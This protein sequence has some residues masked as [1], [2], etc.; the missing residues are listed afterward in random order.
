MLDKKTE[1]DGTGG[2]SLPDSSIAAIARQFSGG[3]LI[4]D[5]EGRILWANQG[6]LNLTG[7]SL[8]ELMGQKPGPL[9]QGEGT[10]PQAVQ[11]ISEHIKRKE[12]FETEI[13]N[14]TREGKPYTVYLKVDP[15]FSENGSV[16]CFIGFQTDV[17]QKRRQA[18]LMQSIL[19]SAHQ[20]IVTLDL[21]GHILTFNEEA[22]R[23]LGYTE[24]EALGS[25]NPLTFFDPEELT[26][27][28]NV[29]GQGL[30]KTIQANLDL[31]YVIA[32]ENLNSQF[33]EWTF[34]R[35][36]GKK[37]Y[38][39]LALT[40]LVDQVETIT[41]FLA[42]IKDRTE[43]H[44]AEDKLKI[45]AGR[46]DKLSS[47]L[48]GVIYQYEL[49]PDGRSR[50]PYASEAMVSIYG[51]R[52]E[53]VREDARAVFR[54]LH[55]EDRESV[56]A[57]I[58]E[59]ART[60]QPWTQEYRTI[61]PD[62]EVRWLHGY[63]N[64]EKLDNGGTLWHGFITDIS[65]Q[66]KDERR[67]RQS[68]ERLSMALEATRDGVWDWNLETDEVFWSPRCFE[69]LG[70][71][72][73]SFD[74][75]FEKWKSLL[76]PD[77]AVDA[78]SQVQANLAGEGAP[79]SI[80]FRMKHR[81]GSYRWI[82]GKGKITERKADGA[83]LRMVGTHLDVSDRMQKDDE[84]RLANKRLEDTNRQLELSIWHANELARQAEAANEAKSSFIAN[85]SHEIRTPMTSIL[86]YADLLSE[87]NLPEEEF[88]DHLR[89][90]HDAGEHLM[91]IVN[92]IL[93]ISRIESG[94]IDIEI[95]PVSPRATI[96][97]VIT[98]LKA[99]ARAKDLEI[100]QEITGRLPDFIPSDPGRLRQILLNLLGNAI[101]FTSRGCI[102]IRANIESNKLHIEVI[103]TGIGI[104]K[105]VL[106]NLFQP[107]MQ[108]DSST[109]RKYGGS[110]LGL[111]ISQRLA[112]ILGGEITVESEPG[113][114]SR[115]TLRIPVLNEQAITNQSTDRG[116]PVPGQSPVHDPNL[117]TNPQLDRFT[118][119]DI[120]VPSLEGMK[121]LVVEDD[122]DI[123]KI[124]QLYL[125]RS[126]VDAEALENGKQALDRL[127]EIDQS[128]DCVLMDIQMPE[129]DGKEVILKLRE[130]GY[131]DPVIAMTAH[132]LRSE[133]ADILA[134]GFDEYLA[135]PIDRKTLHETLQKYNPG[136]K[137]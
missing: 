16:E 111:A 17:T 12:S 80:T 41:G 102:T 14:Y 95:L 133:V 83:P 121:V 108:A 74:V 129:M 116:S 9:L 11:Q 61:S 113:Q 66:K 34:I 130:N 84:L 87:R 62:G 77:E 99:K 97:E 23:L 45:A 44:R 4:T 48:P 106:R 47:L 56:K 122:P 52:P 7:Y 26:L 27:R 22:S 29:V 54:T 39:E 37:I 72:P 21:E 98:M 20:G 82:S 115:F 2:S 1:P 114:G 42:I 100:R 51:V 132:A 24:S 15:V 10:D 38:G 76:H 91:M 112:E 8:P 109:T 119:P 31:L 5:P 136:R 128:Y 18:Q 96:E 32:T 75:T 63:A 58:E 107:F 131:S 81:D 43:I 71:D 105:E 60:M 135:K 6:F 69:M 36:D 125:S 25:L 137:V 68:E 124:V 78:I 46:L 92:D 134:A 123:R 79:F 3:I 65:Q 118:S 85:M 89:S 127:L 86:G 126:K 120:N 101:K 110:G 67:L 104:E 55:P 88:E 94:K 49:L 33:Q 35:K 93:D 40:P 73:F 50:F 30:Q 64:P 70:Y 59:S 13:L 57:A 117:E 90:L 53:E 28:A 19:K 103:D